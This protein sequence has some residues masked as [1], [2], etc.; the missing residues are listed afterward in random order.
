MNFS[1]ITVSRPKLYNLT[2]SRLNWK[3]LTVKATT[4]LGPL[5]LNPGGGGRVLDQYLGIGEPQ[6]V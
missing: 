1:L 3:K 4:P 6:R 5:I 2:L